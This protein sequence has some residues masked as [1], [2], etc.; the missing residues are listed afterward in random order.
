MKEMNERRWWQLRER[1]ADPRF[2]NQ[3]AW[4][5]VHPFPPET[6]KLLSVT[7]TFVTHS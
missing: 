4:A 6:A 3:T 7:L 2:R 5:I 1:E